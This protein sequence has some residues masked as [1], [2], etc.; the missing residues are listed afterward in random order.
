MEAWA[1]SADSQAI[2]LA[3]QVVASVLV[4]PFQVLMLT[5]LYFDLLARHRLPTTMPP[6]Q[7]PTG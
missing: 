4:T 2:S 3:G 6:V 5:L 7:P 1:K